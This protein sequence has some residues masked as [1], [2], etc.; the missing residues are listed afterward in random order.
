MGDKTMKFMEFVSK[1]E[2]ARK[3]LEAACAGISK[4]D[5]KAFT[6][7][8]VKVAAKHGFTLTSEDFKAS[9]GELSEDE[10]Q[11]VA[12]GGCSDISWCGGPMESI[13]HSSL[14]WC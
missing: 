6:E 2:D 8:A 12:G 9:E 4:E 3:E 7:A 11:A 1:N 13:C 14:T 10:M 5:K